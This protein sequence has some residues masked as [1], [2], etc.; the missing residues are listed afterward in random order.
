MTEV[1]TPDLCVIGAGSAGLSVAAAAA[2]LG[3]PVVLIERGKMGGDCLN[4][5]CVPSKALLAAAK[6][7]HAFRTAA[8]FGI[9]SVEPKIDWQ[10]VHD[11][12]RGVI[13]AIA[14][15]DSVERFTGLG[16]RVIQAEARFID[17]GAVAAG[18]FEIRARRFVIATGSAPAT[19]PIPGLDQIP[20]L[21][22]ETIFDQTERI[23]HLVVI[24]GGPIGFEMAQ[25]HLRLGSDVTVVEAG[26]LLSKD[27]PETAAV[28]IKQ[29]AAEGVSLHAGANVT[30]VERTIGGIRVRVTA[31]GQEREIVGTHLLIATGRKPTTEGLGLDR[32]RVRYDERGIHVN[33]KLKTRNRKIYAI[34][35]VTGGLQFTHI[36]SYHAGLVV[37]NAL[38]RLPVNADKGVPVWV[39]YTEPELAQVGM[40]EV[41]ALSAYR[42]VTI[43]RWPYQENDRAQAERATQGFIKV[44][45]T[46]RGRIVGASIVGAHAGEMAQIWVLAITKKLKIGDLASL[47][48]PYPTLAEVSKR[49]AVSYYLPSLTNPWLRRIMR[50][51]R[52]FG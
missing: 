8:P 47:I 13:T 44:M 24:G 29:L 49:V 27:D 19:P 30:G 45:T 51:V 40:T 37:R 26:R 5:G 31:E 12:V 52:K 50:L 14:P 1:L 10:R 34:G 25:A 42:Q 28:L 35:D 23:G 9:N 43:L 3:A 15:N 36:A 4:V 2:Q 48:L 11:H 17:R 20:Y 18:E 39:T 46:K 32:A 33:R 16:V 7:A 41:Q 21:T 22:N 6:R 38:F